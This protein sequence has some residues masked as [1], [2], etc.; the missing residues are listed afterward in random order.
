MDLEKART[1]NPDLVLLNETTLKQLTGRGDVRE[2][3]GSFVQEK[4]E[5]DKE[6]KQQQASIQKIANL[7]ETAF[8]EIL[9]LVDFYSSREDLK[10]EAAVSYLVKTETNTVLFDLGGNS[11][12]S[13]P[14]PLPH[15]MEKLGV[16]LEDVDSIVISHNHGDHTGGGAWSGQKTFSW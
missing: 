15:N 11:D 9:P 14:S 13:D 7:G 4:K 8:L 3:L 6:W 2:V 1:E 5:A 16:S 12:N 10:T